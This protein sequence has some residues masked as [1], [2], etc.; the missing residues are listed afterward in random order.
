MVGSGWV[1]MCAGMAHV[2]AGDKATQAEDLFADNHPRLLFVH[3]ERQV[4]VIDIVYG[5][6]V[7]IFSA[8][9]QGQ[10]N[11]G[12]GKAG[13]KTVCAAGKI[14]GTVESAEAGEDGDRLVCNAVQEGV[15]L[16]GVGTAS[17]LMQATSGISRTRRR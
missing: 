16:G 4:S 13:H 8:P 17:S 1:D 11:F 15:I 6:K 10:Q 14:K 3:D 5:V 12:K 7:F 2:A 9:D